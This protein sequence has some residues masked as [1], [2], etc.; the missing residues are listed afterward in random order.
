MEKINKYR[1]CPALGGSINPFLPIGQFLAPKW[2]ILIWC[3]ID[4]LFFKVLF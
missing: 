4:I 2:I 3:L 1:K